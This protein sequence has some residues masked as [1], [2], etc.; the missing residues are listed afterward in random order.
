MEVEPDQELNDC[1]TYVGSK[2]VAPGGRKE[3]E[4]ETVLKDTASAAATAT[5]PAATPRKEEEQSEVLASSS[6]SSLNKNDKVEAIAGGFVT[7]RDRITARDILL[8]LSSRPAHARTLLTY[9]SELAK[10]VIF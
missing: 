7:T 6:S 2:Y 9:R 1:G 10:G 8:S 5:A 4:E 3:G